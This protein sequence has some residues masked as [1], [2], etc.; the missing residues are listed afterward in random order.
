V[1]ALRDFWLAYYDLRRLTL[2]DFENQQSLKQS[3]E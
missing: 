1:S 2:Y 3:R